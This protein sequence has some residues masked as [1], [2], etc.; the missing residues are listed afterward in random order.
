MILILRVL[1]FPNGAS[2]YGSLKIEDNRLRGGKEMI[3]SSFSDH[4]VKLSGNC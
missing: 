1:Q 4:D 3:L 2:M